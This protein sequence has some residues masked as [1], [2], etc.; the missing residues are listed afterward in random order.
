MMAKLEKATPLGQAMVVMKSN[1]QWLLCDNEGWED[2][3][4]SIENR[5]MQL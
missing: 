5:A 1:S 2:H 3:T 4:R